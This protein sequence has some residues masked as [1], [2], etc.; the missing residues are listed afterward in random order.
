MELRAE[1]I[2]ENFKNIL[3]HWKADPVFFHSLKCTLCSLG[4]SHLCLSQTQNR[5][6][7][8]TDFNLKVSVTATFA[9]LFKLK[10]ITQDLTLWVKHVF[11]FLAKHIK[12]SN[13]FITVRFKIVDF[14]FDV[15]SQIL[16]YVPE[17]Q[18][19]Q[20]KTSLWQPCPLRQWHL[21]FI[22]L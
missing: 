17:N 8:L 9:N 15:T 6:V 13:T 12:R 11:F 1:N 4:D 20:L 22:W 16:C 18:A 3:F 14:W 19:I 21:A 2:L 10:L 7:G 5:H